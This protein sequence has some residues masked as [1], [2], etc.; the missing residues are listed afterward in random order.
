[1]DGWIHGWRG[2]NGWRDRLMN[3]W[4]DVCMDGWMEAWREGWMDDRWMDE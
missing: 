1:M 2:K 3:R 4:V